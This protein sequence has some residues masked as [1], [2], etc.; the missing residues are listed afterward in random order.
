MAILQQFH[1]RSTHRGDTREEIVLEKV[2]PGA[3]LADAAH[4]CYGHL[5]D[6][7][8]KASYRVY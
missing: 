7:V 5:K 3:E 2:G 4:E 8:P 6:L 1:N